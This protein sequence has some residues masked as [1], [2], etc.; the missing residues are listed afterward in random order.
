MK[1]DQ[2]KT[3]A[4]AAVS[5]TP[6]VRKP[7]HKWFSS[8][9]RECGDGWWGPHDTVEAA[10]LE[11]FCNNGSERI[12]VAQGRRLRQDEMYSECTWEVDAKNAFEI[13]LPNDQDHR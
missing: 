8:Y 12:F 10:A 9:D 5:S 13:I 7:R 4:P 11:C 6:L 1:P 2:S 3:E